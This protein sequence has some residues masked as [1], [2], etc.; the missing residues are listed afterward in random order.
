MHDF[1]IGIERAHLLPVSSHD[2]NVNYALCVSCDSLSQVSHHSTSASMG[3]AC[4]HWGIERKKILVH[5]HCWQQFSHASPSC[6]AKFVLCPH[7]VPR[8]KYSCIGPYVVHRRWQRECKAFTDPSAGTSAVV[9]SARLHQ[10]RSAELKRRLLITFL[11]VTFFY[12]PSLLT[13]TLQTFACFHIDPAGSSY[14]L[15]RPYVLPGDCINC[16][17]LS[18]PLLTVFIH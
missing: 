18:T 4:T 14:A 17:Y 7:S 5:L 2:S 10:P 13:A 12:D 6:C 11:E 1:C 15:V 9:L 3:S 16:G 8:P